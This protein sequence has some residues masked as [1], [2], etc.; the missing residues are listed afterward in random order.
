MPNV[1]NFGP[2]FERSLTRVKEGL[3]EQKL[4]PGNE[5]MEER[6][7]VR[8][9]LE[10]IT[11][12][13]PALLSQESSGSSVPQADV[14]SLPAYLSNASADPRVKEEVQRLVNLAF[15]DHIEKAISEAKRHP[16]FVMDALHDALVDKLIP[17]MKRRG[18]L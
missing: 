2:D 6:E 15:S 14:S 10:K 1:V 11:A 16:P 3:A 18:M 12:T 5:Q 9:S 13:V 4:T 8:Q 17:E 7:L